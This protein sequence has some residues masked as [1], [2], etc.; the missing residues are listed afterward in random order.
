MFSSHVGRWLYR[1]V[2]VRWSP[3]RSPFNS[4]AAA[5]MASRCSSVGRGNGNV[6][7]KRRRLGCRASYG[8]RGTGT[9]IDSCSR[10]DGI[11]VPYGCHQKVGP[12]WS[13]LIRSGQRSAR[14]INRA[15]ILLKSD[16]G[17]SAPQVAAA[18]DTSQRTVFPHQAS[19]RR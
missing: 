13:G 6:S 7:N 10:S 5:P 8:T 18:L 11:K 15:R 3:C 12:N 4:A 17:W 1:L 16:E 9:F 19:V 2:S 14:V